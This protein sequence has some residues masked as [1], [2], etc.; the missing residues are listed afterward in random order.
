MRVEWLLAGS[1][2]AAET[3]DAVESRLDRME[4][5]LERVE[6]HLRSVA[7]NAHGEPVAGFVLFLPSG[8]G[9]TIVEVDAAPLPVGAELVV[10]G[11]RFLIE[12]E[13]ASPFPS[14]V[15]P[16]FVLAPLAS[17]RPTDASAD[18]H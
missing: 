1:E 4:R 16:C 5:R 15:R 12:R 7:G 18:P 9:Y 3:G 10:A 13:R 8:P 6:E 17:E 14:D 11:S 2:A